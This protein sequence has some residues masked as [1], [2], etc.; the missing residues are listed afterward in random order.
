MKCGD[1]QHENRD[2]ARFCE[3]CGASLQRVCRSCGSELRP[4]AKFCDACGASL[5]TGDKPQAASR[6][7]PVDSSTLRPFDSSTAPASYTPKHLAEKILNSRSA[8][9][10]ER[11]QVTVLFADVKSSMELAEQVDPEE[12]HKILESFFQIL[13]DGVHRFEGTVNQ[14]TGDGIMAL[15]GAPIAHEDHAQ[16]A[17]YAALYLRDELRRYAEEVKR[18]RGVAFA[19]RMGINSGE[20]VVGKIGDDLRMDYTAQG[21]TVGL[22]QRV[23]QLADPGTAYLGEST[24][25]IV[26]GFFALRDLG[27]FDLKGVSGPQRIYELE[28]VGTMR[29]R[30]DRSRARGFSSFVGRATEMKALDLA[31]E[32]ADGG[33]GQVVAIVGEA[34][35]GKS[36]LC[37]EF[38]QKCRARD[39]GVYEAHCVAHGKLIPLL[40]V[41]EL[42]RGYFGVTEGDTAQ[43]ARRKIAGTIVLLDPKLED[44]LP[45]VFDFMGVPDPQRPVPQLDPDAR[46]RR[47]GEVIR[48]MGEAR[49]RSE[50]AVFCVDDLHWV[51]GASEAYIAFLAQTTVTIRR[52]LL[53]NFRPE[54]EG[55]WI[56]KSSCQQMPLRPLGSEAIEE[57]LTALLGSDPS[58]RALRDRIAE[59]TGGNPFFIEEVVQSLA[60]AGV[61]QGNRGG[62]QVAAEANEIAIPG[63]VQAVLAARIDRL[64]EREKNALQT[65]AV[66]GK[67]FSE[68]LLADVLDM[69][70]DERRAALG[71]LVDAEFLDERA[72]YPTME[73]GFR[74]PIG[75]EVAYQSQLGD[76]RAGIHA[77]AAR[78][79]ARLYA[80]RNDDRAALVAHHYEKAGEALPAATWLG[81]AARWATANQVEEALRYWRRVRELL[82]D[83]PQTVESMELG[84]EACS[85][86]LLNGARL[87]LPE[88]EL[89]PL[90]LEGVDLARRSGDKRTLCEFLCTFI[91]NRVLFGTG[92]ADEL[93]PVADEV[94][95]LGEE[96]DD[97]G[98]RI[99]AI[100]ARSMI[101]GFLQGRLNEALT[102][103]EEACA[104]LEEHQ[105]P[106]YGS[107]MSPDFL[108][109][110]TRGRLLMFF[111]RPR[112]AMR[113]AE[114]GLQRARQH[115]SPAMISGGLSFAGFVASWGPDPRAA[116]EHG[117]KA[118][119]LAESIGSLSARGLAYLALGAGHLATEEWQ[120]A[121]E[122]LERMLSIHREHHTLTSFQGSTLA[123]LAQAC[124]EKGEPEKAEALAREAMRD[125]GTRDAS[126]FEPLAC[127]SL[128]QVLRR[129]D[130]GAAAEEIAALL[131][132]ASASIE[133]TGGRLWAPLLHIERAELARLHGDEA[134]WESQ[135]REAYR[136]LTEMG[137]TWRAEK[138]AK[139]LEGGG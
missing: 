99:Q 74:H 42:L 60:E 104:L 31:L 138:V 7:R 66:L 80:E 15:F 71:R 28:G 37:H 122:A 134:R 16:R 32:Q 56:R 75:E 128:A 5:V 62:Y 9:E 118:V 72:L 43:A 44:A 123:N 10:G 33:S 111:G 110:Q 132:Q 96:I 84:A 63:S 49:S 89:A 65:A 106:T 52:L 85:S 139:A 125:L 36:R 45:L 70:D 109:L 107:F 69:T 114:Q 12:W 8:L 90:F 3:H 51:D 91:F 73:Y 103:T 77:R 94:R 121:Q 21:H 41:L 86:L 58:V 1:C 23:E 4:S 50:M 129:K 101:C 25:T 19:T 29:T 127:L 55:D 40:P 130:G 34:G 119:E 88:A 78:H 100:T 87:G 17:C 48:R 67:T 81:R 13:N 26:S 126:T 35:V 136:L 115:E 59:K 22:A 47:M 83:A 98:A 24:G 137:C 117:R 105:P 76:R 20:V 93:V 79:L 102:L 124:L 120:A 116:V 14:Y 46:Q 11:K 95:R 82:R 97:V 113:F 53:L 133:R 38:L 27:P 135:L 6:P 92:S 54:Y 68:D 57:L 64:G 61:L 30:L 131:E 18:T 108:A 112:E 2:A 39:I